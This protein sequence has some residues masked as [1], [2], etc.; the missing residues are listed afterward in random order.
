MYLVT[1]SPLSFSCSVPAEKSDRQWFRTFRSITR[2]L[3]IVSTGCD[4]YSGATCSPENAESAVIDS[5]FLCRIIRERVNSRAIFSCFTSADLW[6]SNCL[7]IYCHLKQKKKL[8]KT[9]ICTFFLPVITLLFHIL[10]RYPKSSLT[11]SL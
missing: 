7:L 11:K 8:D 9:S 5:V 10:T 1:C 3:S 6:K 4:L 2:T